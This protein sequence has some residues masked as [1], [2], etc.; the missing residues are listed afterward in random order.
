MDYLAVTAEYIIQQSDVFLS[1]A[2][3]MNCSF[4]EKKKKKGHLALRVNILRPVAEVGFTNLI[5]TY[6]LIK[7]LLYPLEAIDINS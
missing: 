2:S 4:T 3:H 5:N 6:T 7:Y 1:R